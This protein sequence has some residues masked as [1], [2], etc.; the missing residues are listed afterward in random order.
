MWPW[1]DFG[2]RFSALKL[3]VFLALFVPGVWLA[4]DFIMGNLGARPANAA[5]RETGQWMIRL[6][7][8]SLAITPFRE[9]LNWPRLLE[10]RR[11]IGVAAFA[12]GFAHLSLYATQE[13][14]NL[15]KVA[16]EIVL[17]IYLTIG[18]VGLI[19]LAALAATSTD[20]MMRR[21][22]PK[23]QKLHKSIYVIAVLAAV[24]F[25]LQS[26]ANVG[27]PIMMMGFY[28]WLMGYR[29][30]RRGRRRPGGLALLGLGLSVGAATAGG[31]ALYY[32]FKLGVSP[33]M[34]L[35]ANLSLGAGFRPAWGV[36]IGASL[37]L[38]A[39]LARARRARPTA[40]A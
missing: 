7:F 14:W 21:M 30:L 26:K 22:G 9:V 1:H 28:L 12:Y 29:F 6:L 39:L 37:A 10:V 16:T 34:I 32:F 18:F 24:H 20:A 15:I 2:G 8:V 19:G 31:E 4:G 23:W 38:A 27:E 11:M 40:P 5:V 17:R 35:A 13:M 36:L 25:F 3:G 33:L